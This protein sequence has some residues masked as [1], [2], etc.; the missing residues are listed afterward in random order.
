MTNNQN[1]PQSDIT[2]LNHGRGGGQI[3]DGC[4]SRNQDGRSTHTVTSAQTVTATAT[5]IAT[6]LQEDEEEEKEQIESLKKKKMR[7]LYE[8]GWLQKR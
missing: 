6:A 8:D 2:Q 4:L 7:T 3:Q 1:K 5:T